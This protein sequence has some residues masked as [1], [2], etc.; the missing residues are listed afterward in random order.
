MRKGKGRQTAIAACCLAVSVSP[1]LAG[2][3]A[4][5]PQRGQS[6]AGIEAGFESSAPSEQRQE[7]APKTAYKDGT[8]VGE[9]K[10]MGG[11]IS[12]TLTVAEGRVQV[13]EIT[14]SG[15]TAGIG[16]K[17]AIE[18]GTFKAQI[19]EAQSADID[20]VTGATMTTGGVRKAVEDALSQAK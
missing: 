11:T 13:D 2:C 18:D 19:E 14:E 4:E 3:G 9:G 20:G 17:E 1:V 7:Q 15:E 6:N 12:V 10:G 5:A 8:Y 16:G